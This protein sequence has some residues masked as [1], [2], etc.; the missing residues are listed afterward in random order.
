MTSVIELFLLDG[1]AET[2]LSV[3]AS[4]WGV[5]QFLKYIKVGACY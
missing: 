1:H 3:E 4:P 5:L 2:D